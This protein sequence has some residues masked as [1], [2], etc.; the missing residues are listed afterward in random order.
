MQQ[1]A[2]D[3]NNHVASSAIRMRSAS[4]VANKGQLSGVG[5]AT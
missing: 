4:I 5:C 3:N 1:P 2:V